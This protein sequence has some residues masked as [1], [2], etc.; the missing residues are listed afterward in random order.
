MSSRFLKVQMSVVGATLSIAM[1]LFAAQRHDSAPTPQ[2]RAVI[3]LSTTTNPRDSGQTLFVA[4][5]HWGGVWTMDSMPPVRLV[6]PLAVIRAERKHFPDSESLITM[7][8]VASYEREHGPVPQGAVV[9]VNS[10]TSGITPRF[11]GDALR[12]LVEA[13]NVVGIGNGGSELVDPQLGSYLASKG[14]YELQDV[15]DLDLLPRSGAI[16]IVAPQHMSGASE[17]PARIMAL[18]R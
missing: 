16:T 14:I 12:F 3:D 10:I 11:D 1:L 18:L 8:D 7:D 4:P 13:R 17:G 2:F 15:H 9:L 6:A 5:A